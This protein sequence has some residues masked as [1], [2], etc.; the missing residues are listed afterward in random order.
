MF[1]EHNLLSFIIWSL[2]LIQG[3]ARFFLVS[4]VLIENYFKEAFVGVQRVQ[5][6]GDFCDSA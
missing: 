4:E 2:R 6:I 3:I 5:T 1:Y